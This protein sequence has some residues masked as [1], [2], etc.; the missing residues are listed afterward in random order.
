MVCRRH[1]GAAA[2]QIQAPLPPERIILIAPFEITGLDF[3]GP[4]YVKAPEGRAKSYIALFTC[5][6][7][8]AVH[9]E[10]VPSMSTPLTHLAIRRFLATYPACRQFITD[11]GRSFVQAATELKRMYNCSR[12]P[13]N[14]RTTCSTK[15]KLGIQLPQS[16]MA[17]LIFRTSCRNSESGSS[18]DPRT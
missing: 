1:R 16:T 3:C 14:R 7:T 9:L 13:R 4:F 2:N 11:N 8:R 17:R 18:Q 12:D 10:L 15:N 5:A 6:C